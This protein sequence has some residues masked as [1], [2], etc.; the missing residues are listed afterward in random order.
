MRVEFCAGCGAP[1]EA[2][3][4][5][6][7]I[8]C[9]YCGVQSLP[10]GAGAPVPSSIPDDGRPRIAVGGR[11]YLILGLVAR[12]DSSYVHFARWVRRLGELVVVKIL[13]CPSDADLMR[14][15][16][17]FLQRLHDSPVT[18]S[19]HFVERIPEPIALSPVKVHGREHLVAVH[20]W[21]SGF[22]HTLEDVRRE[23]PQG[24]APEVAVWIFKRILETLQWAHRS[25]VVHSSVLPPHVLIH[26]RD[27]GAMLLGWS[28]AC[29]LGSGSSPHLL[30]RNRTW[31]D[32]Y[33]T[34]RPPC[35]ASDIAM[36]A[37]CVLWVSGADGADESGQLPAGLAL[38]LRSAARS[39]HDDAFEL[40]G[41]VAAQSLEDLG[42]PAYSP[43]AMPGWRR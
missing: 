30:A 9:R 38:L 11:T 14:R 20:R 8:E 28:T 15:E 7:V 12:G 22:L 33:P 39:E 41:Q 43:L 24:I 26:P 34:E 6:I 42:P 21:H 36:A 18:G 1:L 16:H 4:S 17:A 37:H 31:R 3:W 25:G 5:E 29:A 35:Q 2:R 19:D 13:R 23:Y 27:H 10:G 40:I 32:W